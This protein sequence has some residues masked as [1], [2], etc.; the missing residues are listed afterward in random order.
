MPN[1]C[2]PA[3]TFIIFER[4]DI[5]CFQ[6]PSDSSHKLESHNISWNG[7][8]VDMGA[9]KT[10]IGLPQAKAY[11]RFIGKKFKLK[12]N[13]NVYRFGVG[14]QKSLG[15]LRITLPTPDSPIILEIDVV[16]ADVPLLIGLDVLDQNGL[17]ADTLNNSL[18]CPG[19]GWE[20][21]LVRKLGHI[22]WEWELNNNMF[23]HKDGAY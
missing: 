8:C 7:A 23:F 17:T 11:C 15:S 9:Q 5:S 21:P 13:N 1:K 3:S 10:V 12:Q 18:K 22:Y 16:Q 20:I 2:I 19:R 4:E 14:K 6:I